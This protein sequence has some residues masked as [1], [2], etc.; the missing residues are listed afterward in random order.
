[1]L[2]IIVQVPLGQCRGRRNL[3]RRAVPG[4]DGKENGV[5][6]SDFTK[7]LPQQKSR[8]VKQRREL[9]EQVPS[10]VVGDGGRIIEAEEV[11]RQTADEEIRTGAIRLRPAR[12]EP[13]SF[14]VTERLQVDL[15]RTAP[16]QRT[17][18]TEHL[19]FHESEV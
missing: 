2:K 1:M 10:D 7:L 9:V 18:P 13:G 4:C 16:E 8:F 19:P 11:L 15:R 5:V 17:C 14:Q 6:R 12:M 3:P